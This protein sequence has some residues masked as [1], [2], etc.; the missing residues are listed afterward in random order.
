MLVVLTPG[1]T[2][3]VGFRAPPKPDNRLPSRFSVEAVCDGTADIGKVEVG[4]S[5]PPRAEIR[6]LMKLGIPISDDGELG[7]SFSILESRSPRMTPEIC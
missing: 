5:T 6:S 1:R 7:F 4:V 2:I 3:E